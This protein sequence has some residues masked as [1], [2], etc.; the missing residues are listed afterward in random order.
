MAVAVRDLRLI[1]DSHQAQSAPPPPKSLGTPP[2]LT[3][4]KRH[5]AEIRAVI[6]ENFSLRRQLRDLRKELDYTR[7]KMVV[8][9]D[10]LRYPD[11]C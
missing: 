4:V 6:K 2:P 5:E 1:T 8:A 7:A 9:A 11:D 10:L 3:R